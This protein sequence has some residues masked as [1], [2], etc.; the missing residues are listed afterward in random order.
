M[1]VELRMGMF[2]N[3]FNFSRIRLGEWTKWISV[4]LVFWN[5]LR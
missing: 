5:I 3:E 4:H 2:V 1:Y